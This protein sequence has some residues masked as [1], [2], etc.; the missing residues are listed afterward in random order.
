MGTPS[1]EDQMRFLR[2]VQALLD[3]GQFTATSKFALLI[4][5]ADVAVESGV[6]DDRQLPVPVRSLAAKFIEYC[7]QQSVPFIGNDAA[8][9]LQQNTGRQAAVIN[10]LMKLRAEG[11]A[12]LAALR[13]DQPAWRRAVGRI[14][15]IVQ[16]MPLFR[17]QY[18][19]GTLRPFLYPHRVQDGEIELQRGAAYCLR[20]FHTLVTGLAR[21]RWVAMVRQL[22][23]NPYLLG[24]C[25]DVQRFMFGAGRDPIRQHLDVLVELQR[26]Q[27][28][29]CGG[30]LPGPQAHVDHFVPW[31]LYRND[32]LLNL[33][34]AHAGCNL[35]KADMLAAEPHLRNW[36]ARNER[37]D[38][39]RLARGSALDA[40]ERHGAVATA[41]W[42]YDRAYELGLP[43]WLSGRET[44]ELT[45]GYR[46]VLASSPALSRVDRAAD[47]AACAGGL[48]TRR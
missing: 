35:A 4:A 34:A 7:W 5:L 6:T 9:V 11:F 42:A 48:R 30:K 27:C 25:S 32:S 47:D 18:I 23:D 39:D 15:R 14:A 19:G 40:A 2:N 20:Q 31:A 29:Y 43:T 38:I 28:L 3:D 41:R 8:G 36:V 16:E 37:G 12:S 10:A 46:A 45:V 24:R 21:D 1:A 22:S 26:G 13:N 33:V 44:L 17:L